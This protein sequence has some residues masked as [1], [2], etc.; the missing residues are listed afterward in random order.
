M[1]ANFEESH[2]A[3][4]VIEIPLDG[5]GHGNCA[6]G[7]QDSGFLTERIRKFRG[8]RPRRDGTIRCALPRHEEW[9]RIS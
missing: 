8:A 1:L 9:S 6:G 5:R 3:L 2:I 7:L 4:A